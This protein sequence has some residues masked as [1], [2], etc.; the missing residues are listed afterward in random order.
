MTR[1][2]QRAHFAAWILLS[3]LGL[4]WVVWQMLGAKAP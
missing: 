4:A 2:Q 1:S 3:L